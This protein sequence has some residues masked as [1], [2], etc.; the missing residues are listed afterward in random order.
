VQ[1]FEPLPEFADQPPSRLPGI[2]EFPIFTMHVSTSPR[3]RGASVLDQGWGIC[4][5]GFG[6]GLKDPLTQRRQALPS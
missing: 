3:E 5:T 2:V 4:R 1:P 6:F